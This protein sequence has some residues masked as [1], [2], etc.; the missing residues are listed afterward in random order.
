MSRPAL[1]DVNVLI[2]LT[3]EAHVH[4]APV[5]SW[6]RRQGDF[7]WA[8]CTVTQ[9][10]FIRLAAMPAI[11]GP[12]AS[13]RAALALLDETLQHPGHTFWAD[14]HGA[15]RFGALRSPLV[16]GHRQVTDAYLLGLAAE[17]KAALVTLDRGLVA[18]AEAQQLAA[19]VQW[20]GPESGV[21][22]HEPPARY[23]DKA[24]ARRRA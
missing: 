9:L 12:D 24:R 7:E 20:I 23:A 16:V 15:A 22:A 13:P 17:Q 18:L 21:A 4:H 6:L 8:S 5:Q 19:H 1:L 14:R 2:A 3:H 11:G 10:G